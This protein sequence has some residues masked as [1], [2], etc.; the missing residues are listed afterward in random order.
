MWEASGRTIKLR[1]IAETLHVPEK[2]ISGWKAKDKWDK[3][4]GW[5][6]PNNEQSTPM[7]TT[8]RKRGAQPGHPPQG[9]AKPNNINAIK[10][11]A[12]A[13][14]YDALLTDEERE[15][16]PILIIQEERDRLQNLYAMHQITERR[17][18]SEINQIN[19]GA[20][21]IVHRTISQV[22]P[23][24]ARG[25]DGR[26]ITK[27]VRISQEQET[28]KEQLRN[29]TDSLTRVR[30]EMR[31]VVDRICQLDEAEEKRRVTVEA[32]DVESIGDAYDEL[33]IEELRRLANIA[34]SS[35]NDHKD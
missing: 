29:H 12:Y 16:L 23:S 32:D 8:K 4:N 15:I 27:V 21:M 24:G 25:A 33:T 19:N 1:E 13:K 11:G 30:A 18:M 31:R 9:G 6:T 3:K 20:E 2:S 28:R 34:G 7:N 10:H 26:E 22:E 17:L 5:S 14:I 35:T